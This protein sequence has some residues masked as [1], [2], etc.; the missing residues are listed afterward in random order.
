M[1]RVSD[2]RA[3]LE[4]RNA[5][6]PAQ[7]AVLVA[8]LLG[9]AL[10]E[11]LTIGPP[12]IIPAVEAVLL[13]GLVATTPRPPSREGPRRRLLRLGLVGVVSAANVVALLL[14]TRSL[15]QGTT[16]D[17]RDLLLGGAV[18]W[19][20]SVILFAVWFWELD[21]GGPIRRLLGDD[22][23]P[24]FL[25]PQM[26]EEEVAD[27]DWEPTLLDYLYLSLNNAASFSPAETMPLTGRAK[28]LMSVQT[29]GSLT[30]MTIVLSY[31]INSLSGGG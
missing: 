30:T 28:T 10:P 24:D 29:L 13:V 19:L 4:R 18:L 21:R 27:E 3:Q 26:S 1:R 7:G 31:A 16:T 22:R 25:F 12:W 2:T 11:Q 6:W 5:L 20:T 23:R 9:L 8:I 14:L 17:A 15:L